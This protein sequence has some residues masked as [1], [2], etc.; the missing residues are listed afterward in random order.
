MEKEAKSSEKRSKR[1]NRMRREERHIKEGSPHPAI[2][3][4]PSWC[5]E[6]WGWETGDNPVSGLLSPIERWSWTQDGSS[7][8]ISYTSG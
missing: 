3:G 4:G 5:R 2:L 6:R 8:S 7:C 1:K